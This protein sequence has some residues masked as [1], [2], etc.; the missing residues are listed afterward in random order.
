MDAQQVVQS[1]EKSKTMS[2]VSEQ[3]VRLAALVQERGERWALFVP[4]EGDDE[5]VIRVGEIDVVD[6]TL[7]GALALAIDH[8]SK[9]RP[10]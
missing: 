10:S 6:A 3:L 7:E 2:T 5:W 9:S 4:T 8:L 1:T